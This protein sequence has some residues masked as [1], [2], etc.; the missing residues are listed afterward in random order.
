[1]SRGRVAALVAGALALAA[2]TWL[3]PEAARVGFAEQR[4][5]SSQPQEQP[6]QKPVIRVEA[7]FVRVDVYPTADGRPVE[8]LRA[9]DFEILEDGVR[10]TIE[11]FEHVRVTPTPSS[12]RVEPRSVAEGRSMAENP[13]ARIFVVFLDTGHVADDASHAIRRPLVNLLERILGRDDLFALMTPEMSA[14]DLTLARRTEGLDEMLGRHWTWGKRHDL[15]LT[16]PE[17]QK[18]EL[19]YPDIQG[20]TCSVP[21]IA[22]Q[23]ILRRREKIALDALRDLVRYLGGLREERK[24]VIVVSNGWVLYRPD[25]RLASVI[26]PLCR[27][28]PG[29]PGIYVGPGGRLTTDPP[30]RDPRAPSRYEC[31]AARLALAQIDNESEFRDL[32]MEANRANVSFYPVD[33]RGLAAWDHPI[34]PAPPPPPEV[35]HAELR[36]RRLVLETMA[37]TTDG[38]AVLTTNDLDRGLRRISDDLSSY[39]LIGYYSTDARLDGRYRRI[40]VRVKRP[41]VQ[42]RARRGYRAATREEVVSVRAGAAASAP[43]VSRVQAAL[44]SLAGLRPEQRLRTRAVWLPGGALRVTVELDEAV[45]RSPEGRDGAAVEVALS[46]REGPRVARAEGMLRDGRAVVIDVPDAPRDTGDYVLRA[47]ATPAG[48]GLPYQDIVSV[49]VADGRPEALA[50]GTLLWRK[51]PMTG[52]VFV[53]TADPRFRRSETLRVELP[54]AAAPASAAARLLDRAGVPMKVAP[55][56]RVESSAVL[57]ELPLAPLAPGDYLIELEVA[58]AGDRHQQLA[59]FRVVP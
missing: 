24:A 4:Q 56:V 39:Y 1:M 44:G 26:D 2:Q 46:R 35:D 19:C 49:T 21:G 54:V 25:P 51:G 14:A 55:A 16:D 3:T 8:D 15:I 45:R 43:A 5:P 31:D 34:G 37:E 33:P 23:M 10:Q 50:G 22:R 17:E 57:A 18:Y 58:V 11:T 6:A 9:E 38:L 40:T 53:P 41:G 30:H 20:G 48:G 52:P 13:R 27:E 32:L 36:N 7:N 59:A 12:L 28:I 29:R 47:R 42:V